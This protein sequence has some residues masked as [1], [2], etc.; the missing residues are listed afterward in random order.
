M[1]T[2]RTPLRRR[3]RG[4]RITPEAVA[5]F[6]RIIETTEYDDDWQRKTLGLRN[7]LDELLGRRPWQ[8]DLIFT[9]GRAAAPSWMTAPE[10]IEDWEKAAALY[11]ALEAAAGETE[12]A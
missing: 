2:R 1:P 11:R 7:R 8:Q 9:W 12:A 5:L 10:Q 3:G 6:K 4:N